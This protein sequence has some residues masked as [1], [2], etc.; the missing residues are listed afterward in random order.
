LRVPNHPGPRG[1]PEIGY[2][3]CA[4]LPQKPQPQTSRKLDIAFHLLYER[5]GSIQNLAHYLIVHLSLPV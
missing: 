1:R 5:K 2:G 4:Q 3:Q